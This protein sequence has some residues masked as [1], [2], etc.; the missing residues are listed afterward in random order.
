MFKYIRSGW[1]GLLVLLL[2]AGFL[3]S[4]GLTTQYKKYQGTLGLNVQGM[5]PYENGKVELMLPPGWAESSREQRENS[6]LLGKSS[7]TQFKKGPA[8]VM[9]ECLGGFVSNF[10]LDGIAK[11]FVDDMMPDHRLIREPVELDTS[12]GGFSPGFAA[13]AGTMVREGEKVPTVMFNGWKGTAGL[14]CKYYLVGFV[15]EAFFKDYEADL[16]AI[17]RSLK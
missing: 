11:G 12:S 13:Y 7:S 17:T 14:G 3:S 9:V 4:C 2:C 10:D 15:G 6:L 1:A 5:T 16:I 8:Y